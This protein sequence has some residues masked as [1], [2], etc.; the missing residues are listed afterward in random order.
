LFSTVF[1]LSSREQR[2]K[3]LDW[4]LTNADDITSQSHTVPAFS[5]EKNRRVK[6]G[7]LALVR[8]SKK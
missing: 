2:K 7:N 5:R 3:Q 8:T 6:T 1:R 4:L